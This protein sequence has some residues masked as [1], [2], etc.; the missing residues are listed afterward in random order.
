[1]SLSGEMMGRGREQMRCAETKGK[2]KKGKQ[3]R[4]Q[5]SAD[6]PAPAARREEKR[7][8]GLLRG[9]RQVGKENHISTRLIQK[10]ME[11]QLSGG[12][13]LGFRFQYSICVAV[14]S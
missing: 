13:E 5:K 8:G 7:N 3:G 4:Q 10:D 2:R 9:R 1:M 11:S 6:L 14:K 12:I